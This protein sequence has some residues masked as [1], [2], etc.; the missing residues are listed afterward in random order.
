MQDNKN[1]LLVVD[2]EPAQLETLSEVLETEDRI[3]HTAQTGEQAKKLFEKLDIDLLIAD[4]MLPGT[5]GGIDLLEMARTAESPAEVILVTGHGS[6]DTAIEAMKKGAY[7]Y[8]TKPVDIRRLRAL[9]D[10]ALEVSHMIRRQKELESALRGEGAWMGIVGESPAIV[11]VFEQVKAVA[12]IDTTVLI[13]GESGT[14]KELV[15]DAI[16]KVSSRAEGPLVKVNC[17]AIPETLMESELF[18]HE[19]GA[20]TGATDSRPGKFEQSSGGTI[21]LDEIGDVPLRL[22]PKLLRV[23]ENS[24]V[25]RLGGRGSKQ[26]DLRVVSST[27]RDLDEAVRKGEFRQDL[28]YRLRV[29]T[30]DL[31]PLRERKEDIPRLVEFFLNRLSVQLNRKLEA[32]SEEAMEVFMEYKWPGNIRELKHALEQ[33]AIFSPEPVLSNVPE[34]IR[35]ERSFDSGKLGGI[36][37]RDLERTAILETLEECDGDKKRAAE[38]LGIGLRTLYRKL[39]EYGEI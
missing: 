11:K 31:P 36:P 5:I 20:F 19:K 34:T 16:H 17:S 18:G 7:D 39:E 22:Q 37:I 38:I 10:K 1:H 28:L 29:V 14:G 21:V 25:E 23:L 27:N 9:A 3:I 26:L 13:T 2:D 24:T 30:I 15:A 12:P 32:L 4:L 35:V 8:L 6:V 33:M